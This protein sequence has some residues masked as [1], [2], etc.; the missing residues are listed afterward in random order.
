MS[1]CPSQAVLPRTWGCKPHPVHLCSPIDSS[2][3]IRK[4]MHTYNSASSKAAIFN[5]ALLW[6]TQTTHFLLIWQEQKVSRG[7]SNLIM[8]GLCF[9]R[10]C[11]LRSGRGFIPYCEIW[12]PPEALWKSRFLLCPTTC[13][14]PCWEKQ[15]NLLNCV[16]LFLSLFSPSEREKDLPGSVPFLILSS[17]EGSGRVINIFTDWERQ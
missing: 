4:E 9:A 17:K 14:P 16:H 13:E 1:P 11:S 6:H 3:P 2:V 15:G 12:L 10:F 7:L 8:R 5:R